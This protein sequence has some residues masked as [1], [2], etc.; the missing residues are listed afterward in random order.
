MR[1]SDTKEVLDAL[2]G[3]VGAKHKYLFCGVDDWFRSYS[4]SR[5][6]K[7]FE[8]SIRPKTFEDYINYHTYKN[9][10]KPN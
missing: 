9:W 4:A 6:D 10:R 3:E 1:L 7:T 8:N 5:Y 2:A